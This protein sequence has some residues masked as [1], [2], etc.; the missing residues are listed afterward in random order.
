VTGPE[1]YKRAEEMLHFIRTPADPRAPFGDRDALIAAA[2]AHATLALAA[3][4][5]L[6]H[7]RMMPDRDGEQW[8]QAAA[9]PKQESAPAGGGGQ[10]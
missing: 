5:A 8:R 3:A 1:H 10:L 2:T 9:T 4:T 7:D 6:A